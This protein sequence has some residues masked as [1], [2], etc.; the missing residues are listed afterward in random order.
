MNGWTRS[1]V[2]ALAVA[3]L[4]C[5]DPSSG[6]DGDASA[7][8][9]STATDESETSATDTSTGTTSTS[10]PKLDVGF[11]TETTGEQDPCKVADDMDAPPPCDVVA[12]PDSFEP[13]VQ[14]SWGENPQ[15]SSSAVPLVANLTDDNDDGEI[16]LCDIPDV[17][18]SAFPGD[19]VVLDGATGSLHW[20]AP[21]P[22]KLHGQP[23]LGDIDDDGIP[24]VIMRLS[25]GYVAAFEND[26]THKWT[27]VESINSGL[28]AAP[29]LADL[30]NDGDVEIVVDETILDHDGNVVWKAAQGWS[31]W[32]A[33]AVADLD[34]D[35]D[36]EIIISSGSAY[37]HD[38]TVYFP[39]PGISGIGT[40]IYPQIAD[41]DDDGL[42]EVLMAATGGLA[43]L[44]HDGTVKWEDFGGG[45]GDEN[46]PVNIHDFDG[47]DE[48]E[49]GASAL[50]GTFAYGVYETTPSVLWTGGAVDMSGQ[51]GGTAFD[52]LGSGT[53]QAVYAD[54]TT[55]FVYDEVGNVLLSTPRSS[56]TQIEYPVVADVDNDGSAEILAVSNPWQGGQTAPGL[57][58]IRDVEDRWIPARRIWN[59]HTYHVTNVREDGTIP[60][61][62]PKHWEALNTFR[63]QAQVSS[64]GGVCEPEG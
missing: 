45:S 40:G 54:E 3:A 52:F 5:G 42:P 11:E 59:Q 41:L 16:D 23:A 31:S 22:V 61:V 12:P 27:T 32:G 34:G 56:L 44:E 64:G 18:L 24:E 47:D 28:V 20:S 50:M 15:R 38:G 48:P 4:G 1:G 19:I 17:V 29:A 6:N 49:L 26:G 10:G 2:L 9:T 33:S 8:S 55:L 51:S 36:M 57:Q 46:R 43:L 35:D 13:E 25:G 62:E 7:G 30:D 53:A 14:W 63:T 37:H 60:T 58:V 21:F 39:N